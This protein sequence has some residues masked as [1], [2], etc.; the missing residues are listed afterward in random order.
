MSSSKDMG[1]V[2]MGPYG[3]K[4]S[5]LMIS[6]KS[7]EC[8]AQPVH[9]TTLCSDTSYRSNRARLFCSA[10]QKQIELGN[11]RIKDQLAKKR[12]SIPV[13]FNSCFLP[14]V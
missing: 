4:V 8:A 9:L 5:F 1:S 13:P 11:I 6:V 2:E 3:E 7:V 10:N 12:N 14:L